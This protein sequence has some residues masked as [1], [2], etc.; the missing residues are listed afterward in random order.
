[1]NSRGLIR[2]SCSSIVGFLAIAAMPRVETEQIENVPLKEPVTVP[3][4]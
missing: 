4:F 2:S 3:P 1:V